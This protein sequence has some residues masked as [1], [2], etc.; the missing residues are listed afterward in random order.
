[1]INISEYKTFPDRTFGLGQ[2]VSQDLT[3]V[4]RVPALF[5]KNSSIY[6]G[7]INGGLA[8]TTAKLGAPT[9]IYEQLIAALE[10]NQHLKHKQLVTLQSKIGRKPYATGLIRAIYKGQRSPVITDWA[11][12]NYLS[13]AIGMGLIDLNYREDYYS[14]TE[15]GEKAVKLFDNKDNS[16]LKKFMF[17]R[18]MEYPYAAWLLRLMN[19]DPSKWY[20][21]FD[22]G[23]NFGFIDEPGFVSLPENLFVDGLINAKI[24]HDDAEIKRI[25]SN[26]ESTADKYM[27]WLAGVFVFYGLIKQRQRTAERKVGDN[28]YTVSVGPEY[29]VTYD[30]RIALNYVNGGSKFKRSKKRVRWEYLAPKIEN[31]NKRK[32]ARAL[33]LK[34]LSESPNGLAANVISQ[35]IN[36]VR[37]SINSIPEQ[38]IDDAIGLNRLGIEIINDKGKLK[39]KEE[40]YDFTIPVKIDDEFKSSEADKIK[41]FLRPVLKHIDH[42]YLQ[43]VDIAFKKN[44]S[45]QE[46]TQFEI[47]S[48]DLFT[49]EMGFHGRHLG[50]ANKPDGFVYDQTDGWII[51]SKAYSQGF[52]FTA[53]NTDAMSRYI[54]QYRTRNDKSTWWKDLPDNL[55]N[56]QFIYIS[57][58]FTGKYR[59]QLADYEHS[60]QMRGSL[61]EI[62]KLLMLAEKVKAGILNYNDFKKYALDKNTDFEFYSFILK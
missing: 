28:T 34:F 18:L 23:S 55:P 9:S 58:Y 19:Q 49:K 51:D 46:N 5:D 26:G 29:R 12:S 30:G 21:K 61:M 56:T 37:Q 13:V 11:A 60:N 33:M 7:L 20:S 59:Q 53:H 15:F 45:N 10:N 52:A 17:E 54:R 43:A 16:K 31:A 4:V 40:L 47:L 14:I 24:H 6:K 42:H 48:T 1:M 44:T 62:A 2:D 32:T 27:R 38:V 22:L 35:K 39:L 3:D 25:R 8:N 36:V 50:G 57:S 41:T